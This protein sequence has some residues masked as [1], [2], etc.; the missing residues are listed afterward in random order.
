MAT[1]TALG[2]GLSR[3]LSLV[4]A[5]GW[6]CGVGGCPNRSET[7]GEVLATP[8][9]QISSA[10][11][12]SGGI[13][14]DSATGPATTGVSST[15]EPT[16]AP[17]PGTPTD[18]GRFTGPF[19]LELK[20]APQKA[21]IGMRPPAGATPFMTHVV[22]LAVEITLSNGLRIKS[23][24]WESSDPT[25]AAVDANGRVTGQDKVGEVLVTATEAS[26]RASASARIAVVD[27]AGVGLLIE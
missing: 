15:P 4:V 13:S 25:V 23:A 16:R 19:V 9:P 5:A 14:T 8:S 20:L 24:Q 10:L 21:T 26:G 27:S 3:P 2:R 7:A 12:I 22:D 11:V 1:R 6:I 18:P 17:S